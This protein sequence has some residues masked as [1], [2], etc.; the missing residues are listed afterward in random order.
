MSHEE[1]VYRGAGITITPFMDACRVGRWRAIMV[2]HEGLDGIGRTPQEALDDL[3][4]RLLH[5]VAIQVP[6]A[7]PMAVPLSAVQAAG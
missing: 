2:G 5:S 6:Q 3:T 7:R 4:Q 1:T